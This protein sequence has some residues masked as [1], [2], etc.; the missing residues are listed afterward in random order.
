MTPISEEPT[1][2]SPRR[3]SRWLIV[4]S[5]VLLVAVIGVG[6]WQ[7]V[8]LHHRVSTLESQNRRNEV[9]LQRQ[10]S[11]L[12]GLN[13]ALLNTASGSSLGQIES[14]ISSIESATTG[15][16]VSIGCVEQALNSA[17]VNSDGTLFVAIRC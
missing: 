12:G 9:R 6:A 1:D 16:A 3:R 2:V 14:K 15:L 11:Q 8:D 4:V 5:C 17:T 13:G 7:V 10:E